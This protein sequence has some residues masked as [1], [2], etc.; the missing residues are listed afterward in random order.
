MISL[1]GEFVVARKQQDVYAFLT[2][3]N[4]F[5][6]LLPD[7]QGLAIQNEKEFDVRVKVGISHIRGTATVRLNLEEARS[8]V[9]ALY[10]GKGDVPG[11]AVDLTAGFDLEVVPEGT[12]IKW[13]SDSNVHGRIVSVAAGLL[14]PLAKKNLMQLIK[15]LEAA[16]ARSGTAAEQ[17]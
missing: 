13:K 4:R 10:K 15:S 2:D 16:L 8:P 3:P 1:S 17:E 7:F 6:P 11:G 14:Q 5:A 9:Y 12:R